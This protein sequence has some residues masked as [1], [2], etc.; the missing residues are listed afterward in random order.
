MIQKWHNLSASCLKS[1]LRMSWVISKNKE[2]QPVLFL[3]TWSLWVKTQNAKPFSDGQAQ[4]GSWLVFVRFASAQPWGD[5]SQPCA[6]SSAQRSILW[7]LCNNVSA[8]PRAR[9][10]SSM[11]Q[12]Y[13]CFRKHAV[14]AA[15]PQHTSCV[16]VKPSP[17][18]SFKNQ[19]G[20][21]LGGREATASLKLELNM[22]LKIVLWLAVGGGFTN[23]EGP[24]SFCDVPIQ[25]KMQMLFL[26]FLV[27]V[28]ATDLCLEI[29][30]FSKSTGTPSYCL[31]MGLL[32]PGHLWPAENPSA[33]LFSPVLTPQEAVTQSPQ[34]YLSSFCVHAVTPI[35]QS[36]VVNL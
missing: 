23:L 7:R 8:Q 16:A 35:C 20:T 15:A 30:C 19:H 29:C 3:R 26:L 33:D 2:E 9:Q 17:E 27:L 24:L 13:W 4:R 5:A 31:A 10:S 36:D 1:S 32:L 14:C 25:H 12:P 21:Y 6:T 34:R 11:A 18:Q 28:R 22:F